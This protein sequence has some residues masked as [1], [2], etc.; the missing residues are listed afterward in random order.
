MSIIKS[1]EDYVRKNLDKEVIE[2][3]LRV[4]N[5]ALKLAEEEGGD[6]E[7][8]ELAALLHDIGYMK[9][10]RDHARSGVPIARDFLN[11]QGY[12]VMKAGKIINCIIKHDAKENPQTAE[13]KIIWD[14]DCLDRLGALGII[15]IGPKFVKHDICKPEEVAE[16]LKAMFEAHAAKLH[17]ETAK[18]F[19]KE[20]TGFQQKFFKELDKQ[21]NIIDN[22]FDFFYKVKEV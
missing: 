10:F 13:E 19:S 7:V 14:S 21:L 11:K 3:T 15:R 4:R 16:K 2:H 20:F 8:V 22:N 9:G 17:T 1:A 12:D 5:Y 6:K 18:R